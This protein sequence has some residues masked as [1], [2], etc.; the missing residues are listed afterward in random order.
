MISLLPTPHWLYLLPRSQA[1]IWLMLAFILIFLAADRR[2]ILWKE[3]EDPEIWQRKNRTQVE[4]HFLFLGKFQMSWARLIYYMQ[5]PTEFF[6]GKMKWTKRDATREWHLVGI[7]NTACYPSTLLWSSL[8]NK[9]H[10]CTKYS[11]SF[12]VSL[13]NMNRQLSVHHESK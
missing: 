5:E 12:L 3:Q 4:T 7:V 8:I 9:P 6:S 13:F 1:T 10:T 2:F 11:I